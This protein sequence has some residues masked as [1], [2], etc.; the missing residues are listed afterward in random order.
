MKG[1]RLTPPIVPMLRV[2]MHFVTLCVT[3]LRSTAHQDRTQSVRTC[4]PTR[5]VGTIVTVLE[6]HPLKTA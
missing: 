6:S 1:G 2:G 5:S 3:A 4:I